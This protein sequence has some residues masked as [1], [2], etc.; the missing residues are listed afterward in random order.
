MDLKFVWLIPV[1]NTILLHNYL[2]DF[3]LHYLESLL[4]FN[5]VLILNL[6]ISSTTMMYVILLFFIAQT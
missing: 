5:A 2:C 4:L 3:P 6:R 1:M